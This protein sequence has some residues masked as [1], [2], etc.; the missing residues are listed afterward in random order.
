MSTIPAR[1][2]VSDACTGKTH[3][4]IRSI[5]S[6]ASTPPGCRFPK[7]FPQGIL[8]RIPPPLGRGRRF[9]STRSC[10]SPQGSSA[11]LGGGAADREGLS[12]PRSALDEAT[13]S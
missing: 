1:D 3:Y 5:R 7:G 2:Y 12:G 6:A 8:K 11:V 9:S 13:H 10:S 4:P